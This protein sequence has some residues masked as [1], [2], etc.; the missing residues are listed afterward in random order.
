MKKKKS[1][2]FYILMGILFIVIAIFPLIWIK[3]VLERLPGIW[4]IVEIFKMTLFVHT[5]ISLLVSC[6][7]LIIGISKV[8]SRE[9]N[10]ISYGE[11]IFLSILI[12]ILT[13]ILVYILFFPVQAFVFID[14]PSLFISSYV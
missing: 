2:Y 1:G 4:I 3:N 11:F 9:E 13:H 8:S 5:F 10:F 14:L 7:I 6:V 12:L